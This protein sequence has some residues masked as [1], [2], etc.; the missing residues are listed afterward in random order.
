MGVGSRG[1]R[2]APLLVALHGCRHRRPTRADRQT[3]R[4]VAGVPVLV[5]RAPQFVSGGPRLADTG[6]AAGAGRSIAGHGCRRQLSADAAGPGRRSI[7]AAAVVSA[8]RRA[9]IAASV[10]AVRADG[11]VGG[12]AAGR[13]MAIV[14]ARS[15][16]ECCAAGG[17]V[18]AV[19]HGAWRGRIFGHSRRVQR[20]ARRLDATQ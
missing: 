12:V 2:D 17:A 15:A 6:D 13:R 8:R 11:Q 10:I 7:V 3:A 14:L 19:A 4:S 1:R 16:I 5:A 9:D 20:A 18:G